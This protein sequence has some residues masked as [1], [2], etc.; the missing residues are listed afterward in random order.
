[1]KFDITSTIAEAL[2]VGI[3]FDTGG[4]QHSNTNA[5]TLRMQRR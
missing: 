5:E 1:M 2:Y 3:L 4:F